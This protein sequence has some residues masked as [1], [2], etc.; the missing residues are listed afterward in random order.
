[1]A[2]EAQKIYKEGIGTSVERT[3]QVGKMRPRGRPERG[4][5]QENLT[6]NFSAL[7]PSDMVRFSLLSEVVA[8]EWRHTANPP[9]SCFLSI[10]SCACLGS[11]NQHP[12]VSSAPVLH[13]YVS[14]PVSEGHV[15]GSVDRPPQGNCHPLLDRPFLPSSLQTLRLPYL[16]RVCIWYP[17][18]WKASKF[19]PFILW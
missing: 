7:N 12:C 15:P 14:V 19:P 2:S 16:H 4:C 5:A 8:G 9:D 11:R 13:V 10:L 3:F 17:C 18:L 6:V 1:M